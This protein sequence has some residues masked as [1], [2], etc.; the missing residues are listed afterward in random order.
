[1]NTG[2]GNF[3]PAGLRTT[4]SRPSSSSRVKQSAVPASRSLMTRRSIWDRFHR[5]RRVTHSTAIPP[6]KSW[7]IGV[8]SAV[9]MGERQ[10]DPLDTSP[11]SDRN[12]RPEYPAPPPQHPPC[13]ISSAARGQPRREPA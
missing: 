9:W 7:G 4:P 2:S 11:P 10:H 5:A 12:D 8:G 1:M 3:P 13:D 6:A